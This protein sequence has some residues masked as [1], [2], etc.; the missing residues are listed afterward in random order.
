MA[1]YEF[2]YC[3]SFWELHFGGCF[4][5]QTCHPNTLVRFTTGLSFKACSRSWVPPAKALEVEELPKVHTF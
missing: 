5:L 2:S 4:V 3:L 1:F